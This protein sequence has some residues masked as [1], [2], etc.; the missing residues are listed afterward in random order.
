LLSILAM[1][2][3]N[4]IPGSRA[5]EHQERVEYVV[6]RCIRRHQMSGQIRFAYPTWFCVDCDR[7]GT[8]LSG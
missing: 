7:R 4:L 8:L 1:N 2:F 5:R 3:A 6:K